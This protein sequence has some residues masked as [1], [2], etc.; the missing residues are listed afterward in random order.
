MEAERVRQR[1]LAGD[2]REMP[3]LVRA[4]FGLYNSVEDVDKLTQALHRIA[5]GDYQGR[6]HQDPASG[7]YAPQ[8]WQPDFEN[9]YNF[10][11]FLG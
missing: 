8:G 6:Y 2:K 1:M 11:E 10:D 3:G 5:R 7:E 4:S 9:F